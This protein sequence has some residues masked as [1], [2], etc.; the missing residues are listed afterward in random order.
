MKY[1]V[2]DK[3]KVRQDLIVGEVYCC[4]EARGN[5]PL[6]VNE[7]LK[8]KTVTIKHGKYYF[9]EWYWV[10][11][12][13]F[14]Y[15]D[16]MLDGLVEDEADVSEPTDAELL[17][18]AE[19]LKA[20]CKK[21]DNCRGCVFTKH[22]LCGI[23]HCPPHKWE[24]PH[25]RKTRKELLLEKFPN[26]DVQAIINIMCPGSFGIS[27]RRDSCQSNYDDF[28]CEACWNTQVESEEE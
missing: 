16:E 19:M 15:T 26:A 12:N 22:G 28:D 13:D 24:I 21:I 4:D 6:F 25:H 18:A 17:A 10:E 3:V 9:S 8:Y 23:T 11:E 5:G 2:G 1:K 14:A 27:D 20:N 7:M